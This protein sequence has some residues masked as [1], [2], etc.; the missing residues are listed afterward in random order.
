MNLKENRDGQM[1]GVA[2]HVRLLTQA[3]APSGLVELMDFMLVDM[4]VCVCC[5]QCV[6]ENSGTHTEE[7]MALTCFPHS[8]LYKIALVLLQYRRNKS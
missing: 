5:V 2:M 4:Y 6:H 1:Y 3:A 7:P 8:P